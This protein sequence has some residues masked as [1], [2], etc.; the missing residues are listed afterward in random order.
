MR[1]LL[2]GEAP[3]RRGGEPFTGRAGTV[4]AELAGFPPRREFDCVNLLQQWP[5]QDGKGSAFP[6]HDARVAAAAM[7]SVLPQGRVVVVAGK[8]VA[9]AFG[10]RKPEFLRWYAVG[11]KVVGVL[12]HP[13]GINR[14]LN[15]PANREAAGTFLRSARVLNPLAA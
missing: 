1:P 12:P 3:C 5:G 7:L 4:L 13:S 14:W 2:V 8:R 11:G 10:I 9:Q 6:L 15:D